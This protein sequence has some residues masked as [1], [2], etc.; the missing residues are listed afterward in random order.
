MSKEATGKWG[1]E[2]GAARCERYPHLLV[3]RDNGIGNELLVSLD[4]LVS[5]LAADEALHV[6]DGLLGVDSGLVLSGVADEALA[7]GE[8][9]VGGRDTVSLVVGDNL[10]AAVLEDADA[11]I[12][13]AKVCCDQVGRGGGVEGWGGGEVGLVDKGEGASWDSKR[14]KSFRYRN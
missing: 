6:K 7:V 12:G 1:E 5:E 9:Y 11:G 4:T 10:N 13:G 2:K 8:G 3:L 14:W